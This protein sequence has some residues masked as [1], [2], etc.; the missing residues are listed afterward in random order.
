MVVR[1]LCV[2]QSEYVAKTLTDGGN[3]VVFCHFYNRDTRECKLV[4]KAQAK[5]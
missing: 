3:C 5:P 2:F 1:D 4:E